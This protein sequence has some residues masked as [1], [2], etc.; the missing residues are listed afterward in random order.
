MKHDQVKEAAVT[1]MKDAEGQA[2]L[3][4][5]IVPKEADI[6]SLRQSLMQELPAYMMPSHIIGLDSMPLTLNGKLD[7]SA[8]PAEEIHSTQAFVAPGDEKQEMLCRIWEDVLHVQKA[9]IHHS[10]F[11]LGE[12]PLRRF[13]CQPD[14]RRRLEHVDPRFVSVPDDCR[15][16]E[17][18]HAG[19]CNG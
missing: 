8:L 10:F 19:C 11:E 15:T 18:P 12:I 5:Y 2:R 7:K 16:R 3:A 14:S 6:S 9:G 4:A 13:K 1:V 17:A